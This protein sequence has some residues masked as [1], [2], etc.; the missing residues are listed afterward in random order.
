MNK[1]KPKP[2]SD[3][4]DKILTISREMFAENGFEATT[5]RMIKQ[6]ADIAEG[7]LYYY[8]PKGKREIFDTIIAQGVFSRLDQLQID[9]SACESVTSLGDVLMSSF[10]HIWQFFQDEGNYQAFV[11]TVRE[12]MLLSDDQVQMV[13]RALTRL[14]DIFT[15]QF[16]SI[17]VQLGITSS[18]L[19]ALVQVIVA[20]FQKLIYDEL[21]IKENRQLTEAI[22]TRLRGQLDVVLSQL[23]GSRETK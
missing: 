6:Q 18:Q 19:A 3:Q 2:Q 17:K 15:E 4:R 1:A 7:L 20:I 8:F 14:E 22:V 23:T 10:K 5:T 12:R 21:L 16:E 11:I 9:M 13:M